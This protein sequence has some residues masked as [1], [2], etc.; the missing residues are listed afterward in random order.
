MRALV[1]AGVACTSAALASC[2][3]SRTKPAESAKG[4]VSLP[5]MAPFVHALSYIQV[6][7]RWS[8]RAVPVTG[9]T[10][11]TTYLLTATSSAKGWT[12]TFPDRKPIPARVVK[13]DAD[14]VVIETGSYKSVRRPDVMTKMRAVYRLIG[15]DLVGT[16]VLRYPTSSADSLVRFRVEGSHAP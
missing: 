11:S 9:D 8:M 10:T 2:S 5:A 14:S 15:D 12:I 1:V 13:L 3:T 4:E 6:S 16:A 7:G